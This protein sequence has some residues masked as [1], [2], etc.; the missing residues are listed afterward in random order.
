MQYCRKVVI[1]DATLYMADCRDVIP[2]LADI[3]TVFTSPPYS[4][5]RAYGQ[6]N[7]FD[8]EGVVPPA[9]VG[10]R[11]NGRTQVLVNLGLVY[12]HGEVDYYWNPLMRAM[13]AANWK[14]GGWYCWDQL[15][16]LPGRFDGRLMP[17]HEFV[18][19]WRRKSRDPCKWVPT[20]TAG[21]PRRQGSGGMT[22][23]ARRGRTTMSA[24]V[25]GPVRVPDSCLR[26]PRIRHT[27]R[28]YTGHSA[29]MPV[30]LAKAIL[31]SWPGKVCDPF[32]GSGT[33]GCAALE[34]G[35]PFVGIEIHEQ[36]FDIACRR[37]EQ[38]AQQPRLPLSEPEPDAE[39]TEIEW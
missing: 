35:L 18:F 32:M 3:D 6:S 24:H 4:Q 12:T 2:T 15:G 33:T 27:D 13:R 31:R 7:A 14:L 1:G 28:D 5:Q 25:T 21:K 29:Q 11:D 38:V 23:N 19:H 39:Q 10:I 26:I 22:N 30:A 16:P 36:Y 34:L 37:I 9:L 8:W 17:S 20:A